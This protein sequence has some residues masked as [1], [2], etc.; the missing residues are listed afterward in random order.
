MN[1]GFL[2]GMLHSFAHPEKEFEALAQRETVPVGIDGDGQ[3]G[4]VF[5]DEVRLPLRCGAGVE[6]LGDGGM[7][8]HGQS[9]S[10]GLEAGHDLARVH[11]G[12]DQ[13]EGDPSLHRRGLLCEPYLAHAARA[14]KLEQAVRTDG[15]ALAEFAGS[16][17][18]GLGSVRDGQAV[19]RPVV[20][21]VRRHSG[22]CYRV[23]GAGT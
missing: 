14:Y 10:L 22:L 3:A 5:H 23:L 7:I 8:H 16:G 6:N 15:L 19:G 18:W 21:L 20:G 9:L 4:D 2:V 13:F 12:F 17:R 11:A 1:D